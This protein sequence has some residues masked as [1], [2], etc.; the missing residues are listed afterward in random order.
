MMGIRS[1]CPAGLSGMMRVKLSNHLSK[2]FWA[3]ISRSRIFEWNHHKIGY[4]AVE[5]YRLSLIS[6]RS[7]WLKAISESD[8][9]GIKG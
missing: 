5:G 4:L 3:N 2:K 6:L 7:N 1:A 9:P 8:R